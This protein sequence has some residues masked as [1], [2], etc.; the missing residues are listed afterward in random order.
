MRQAAGPLTE[1]LPNVVFCQR[2]S[3]VDRQLS[4][5]GNESIARTIPPSG[6]TTSRLCRACVFKRQAKR[7]NA[8]CKNVLRAK[9]NRARPERES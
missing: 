1:N 9:N 3:R 5:L 8:D 6:E 7:P 4:L 2:V